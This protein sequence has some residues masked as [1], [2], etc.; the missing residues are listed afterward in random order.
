[1]SCH[2]LYIDGVEDDDS[3]AI[4]LRRDQWCHSTGVTVMPSYETIY[5]IACAIV[6]MCHEFASQ[7]LQQHKQTTIQCL[8]A[9]YTFIEECRAAVRQAGFAD[10]I[11]MYL[12]S[13]CIPY[14]PLVKDEPMFDEPKPRIVCKENIR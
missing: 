14:V 6:E 2:S 10:P 4:R 13:Q 9:H 12:D 3:A 1:M 7:L 8:D 5:D 11:G